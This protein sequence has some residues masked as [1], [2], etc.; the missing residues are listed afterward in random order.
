MSLTE[1]PAAILRPMLSAW[2]EQLRGW[3]DRIVEHLQE[4]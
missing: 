2:D 4:S 3:L 1:R